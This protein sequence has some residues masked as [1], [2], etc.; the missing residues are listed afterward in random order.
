VSTLKVATKTDPQKLAG[1]IVGQ[2]K[3]DKKIAVECI[4]AEALNQ[5]IKACII[6]RGFVAP[7]GYGITIEPSFVDI[8]SE[9]GETSGIRLVVKLTE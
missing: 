2:L 5:A 8:D 7:N 9:R 4:G 6:A 1:A 3:N